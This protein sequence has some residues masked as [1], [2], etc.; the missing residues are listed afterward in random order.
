MQ[1][2]PQKYRESG[3]TGC[4]TPNRAIAVDLQDLRFVSSVPKA[5]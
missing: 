5:L 1:I 3:H 4:G 2:K